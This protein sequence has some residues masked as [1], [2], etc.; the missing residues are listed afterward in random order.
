MNL[1][2]KRDY[3]SHLIQASGFLKIQVFSKSAE[4]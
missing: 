4:K 2:K 1:P 3:L